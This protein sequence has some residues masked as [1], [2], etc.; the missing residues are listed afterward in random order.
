MKIMRLITKYSLLIILAFAF[1]SCEDLLGPIDDNHLTEDHLYNTPAY[2][3]GLLITAYTKLPTNSITFNDVATDD[4]VTNDKLNQY[5]RMATGEWSALYNPVSQWNNCNEAILYINKFID[6]IDTVIWKWTDDELNEMYVRRFKGE[7]YA[8]RGLFQF[9]LLQNIGGVGTDGRLLGIPLYD[10]FIEPGDNFN[11]PRATFAESLERIYDDFDRSLEYLTM[12]DYI[13]I[14][15]ASQ[16]PPGLEGVSVSNYNNIFGNET[17]QRISGRVVKALRARVA[18]LA[19]SPAFSDDDP[20]LWEEAANYAAVVLNSIGGPSAL[21]PKG[22]K[23]Y[24]KAQVDAINLANNNDQA[25]IIWRRA[26]TSSRGLESNNF[27]PSLYGNG[28]VNPTQNLVDA[29]PM[30]DGYPVTESPLYNPLNPYVNRDPR[31]SLYIIYDGSTYKSTT[32]RTGIGGGVNAKDSVTTS[33]RTGYYLKKLLREDV[34]MNPVSLASQKH[35]YVHMRYT[36]LFLIYAEAANE[37]WGPDGTGTNGFSA[38]QV[39]AAIRTRA[40]ITQPDNYL[41]SVTTK[42]DMRTLIRNE[43]RIELCFEGFRFW[44]LRRWKSDLTQVARGINIDR[45]VPSFS[46][47]DVEQ[48]AYNNNHMHYGPLPETEVVKFSALIQ[49]E[50]W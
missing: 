25:E 48:R 11:V 39:I 50:G 19:A 14:T 18:L 41:A 30:A 40:G 42:E 1:V 35:Y 20:L 45:S 9:Y 23:Y 3:E 33:T 28:Q 15:D 46:V 6:F 27:P 26:I 10:K 43:R 7:A 37:V 21:D 2:A 5:R 12:D 24:E 36:E 17:R 22:H 13:N 8:L 44:D 31:L 29:F 49:N 4:A 34:N 32:I 16:L 38:R 47:V